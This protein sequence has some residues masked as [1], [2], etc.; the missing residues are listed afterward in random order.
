MRVT[1]ESSD[2]R[3]Q[4][5]DP[6]AA[7]KRAWIWYLALFFTPVVL[8]ALFGWARLL[9][10][11]PR[12]DPYHARAGFIASLFWIGF[13][14][15]A[16]FWLQE[17]AFASYYKGIPVSPR[18]YLR[19]K[20]TCWIC[21]LSGALIACILVFLSQALFPHVFAIC[22][23]YVFMATQYPNGRAMTHPHGDKDRAQLYAEPK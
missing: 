7:L 1:T 20:L 4:P 23:V 13:V 9:D 22:I 16:G 15:A 14:G 2:P 10:T 19:G 6:M 21:L 3:P 8:L 18:D 12:L 5:L 11:A 17:R